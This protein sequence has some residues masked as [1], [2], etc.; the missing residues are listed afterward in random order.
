MT[1]ILKRA[2]AAGEIAAIHALQT[3]NLGR[4]L[5]PA[6]RAREGFLT[7]DYSPAVLAELNLQSPA[8]VALDAGVVVGYALVATP[9]ARALDPSLGGLFASIDAASA[10]GAG[11]AAR[12]YLVCAA[13][14]VAKTHRGQGLLSRLYGRMRKDFA[15]HYDCVMTDIARDNVRSLAAHRRA[16][17]EV[18]GS[19]HYDGQT[20]DLVKCDWTSTAGA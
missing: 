6:E 11:L 15:T 14:C 16:G 1:T 19:Q 12:A 4:H 9:A 18:C 10:A 3:A 13:V 7:S 2:T 5:A 17:F 20:W 8:I